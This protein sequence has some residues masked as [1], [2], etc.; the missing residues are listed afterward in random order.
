MTT[1]EFRKY[2]TSKDNKRQVVLASDHAGV[3]MKA[4]IVQFL[5]SNPAGEGWD[6]VDVGP[7]VAE[8]CDYPDY[9]KIAADE[10][11]SDSKQYGK[12]M[13][14]PAFYEHKTGI[15]ICG[16]GIGISIAANKIKGIRAALCH[17]H[18]TAKLC[19]EHNDANILAIGAR[20]TGPDVATEMVAT[21]LSTKFAGQRHAGR[22]DKLHKLEGCSY[23]SC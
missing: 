14:F 8:R 15:L 7:H 12:L 13:S 21:F 23:N 10:I 16:T 2:N 22:L 17:D 6:I 3:E 5:T 18:F 19:R 20:T 9:A 4:N 1:L 11:L